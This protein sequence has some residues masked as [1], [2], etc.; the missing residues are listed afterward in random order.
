MVCKDFEDS[1]WFNVLSSG[2]EKLKKV[3]DN[4][5]MQLFNFYCPLSFKGFFIPQ[6]DEEKKGQNYFI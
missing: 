3:K 2:V 5:I 6:P 1:L 4:K